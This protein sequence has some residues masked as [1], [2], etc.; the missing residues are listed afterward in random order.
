MD[1]KF[2]LARGRRHWLVMKNIE[3]RD[4]RKGNWFWVDNAVLTDY[5]PKI[6]AL[7][8]T[9]YS[10]LAMLSR[11]SPT[12]SSSYSQLGKLLDLSPRTIMRTIQTLV[13]AGLIAVEKRIDRAQGQEANI[14]S[15]LAVKTSTSN[16]QI[17][18]FTND[19]NVIGGYDKSDT[20]NI[21]NVS[22][23]TPPMTNDDKISTFTNVSNVTPFK[24]EEKNKKEEEK[25]E[26]EIGIS[27]S[28]NAPSVHFSDLI[29]N[30]S[31]AE[32]IVIKQE[33]KPPK[34]QPA[35]S[36]KPSKAKTPPDPRSKHPAIMAV[37]QIIGR[38]PDKL[39]WDEIIENLGE[40]PD[41]EQLTLCA[42][43]WARKTTNIAN[44]DTWLFEWYVSGL[45]VTS[46]QKLSPENLANN[47]QKET[48]YESTKRE[49][50][51]SA[52]VAEEAKRLRRE[53]L[54]QG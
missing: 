7:G 16:Q 34:P 11:N 1:T 33:T 8:F 30:N 24:E 36:E 17:D 31:K 9:L 37:R 28:L 46:Y 42:K 18:K 19:L 20:R 10:C 45:P 38:Y 26:K 44:L 5:F 49:K 14:Y 27:H 41:V 25:K 29:S 32:E 22:T 6:G 2:N 3:I 52:D 40:S 39:V 21:T 51:S 13:D 50:P 43:A 4:T 35:K 15:L 12:V 48:R 54:A 53:R 23:V 47:S